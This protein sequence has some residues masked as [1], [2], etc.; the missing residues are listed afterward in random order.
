[1]QV[2]KKVFEFVFVW[3]MGVFCEMYMI[4]VLALLKVRQVL[5]VE[6]Q[7]VFTEVML[8]MSVLV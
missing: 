1:M 2:F 3:D 8:I 5:L 7:C 4:E 6:S